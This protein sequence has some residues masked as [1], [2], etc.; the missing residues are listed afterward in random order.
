MCNIVNYITHHYTTSK[1]HPWPPPASL[2]IPF[3]KLLIS[4]LN[5][6]NTPA[7]RLFVNILAQGLS[8][9]SPNIC[10]SGGREQR[11]K[12]VSTVELPEKVEAAYRKAAA[13]AWLEASR[14]A[15]EQVVAAEERMEQERQKHV[16][17]SDESAAE[18]EL[19]EKK[20]Q[21]LKF[22]LAESSKTIEEYRQKEG[23]LIE[24]AATAE[25]KC[26]S[27]ASEVSTLKQ[28]LEQLETDN[29]EQIRKIGNLE[30][31]ING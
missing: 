27:A 15:N 19:L 4:C 17:A 10:S 14:L 9:P 2:K 5:K 6:A 18:I 1:E 7:Y 25:T 29:K 21:E 26:D 24:R 11:E 3:S 22:K 13:S 16:Q 23:G 31:K 8:A 28:K 20:E 30:G 12:A